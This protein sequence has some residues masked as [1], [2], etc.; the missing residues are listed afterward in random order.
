MFIDLTKPRVLKSNNLGEDS[1]SIAWFKDCN[2]WKWVDGKIS[3]FQQL[4]T[5]CEAALLFGPDQLKKQL[6][7]KISPLGLQEC[8][9]QIFQLPVKLVLLMMGNCLILLLFIYLLFFQHCVATCVKRVLSEKSHS[10]SIKPGLPAGMKIPERCSAFAWLNTKRCQGLA[11]MIK[12]GSSPLDP[13]YPLFYGGDTILEWWVPLS[14]KH[15]WR[16][17]YSFKSKDGKWLLMQ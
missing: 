16:H 17:G 12:I 8:Q 3:H 15:V 9:R 10:G 6:K 13:F 11:P 1:K 7:K 14:E 2:L 4:R 5:S